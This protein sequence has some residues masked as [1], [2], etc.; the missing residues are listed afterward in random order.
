MALAPGTKLGPYE[1]QSPVG[2]GGMGQVYRARDTRLDRTVAVKILSS[3]L[4]DNPE[5]KKRFNREARAISSLNHPNICTL[6]D[7]GQKDGV[8][9]LVM[10]FLEGETL[11][12]RLMKGAMPRE[13]VLKYGV[14][15]CEGLEK[16]HRSGLVHRDLKPG[17]IMLTKSGVKL[18]DFGLAK[19]TMSPSLDA[20]ALTAEASGQPLTEKDTLVGTFQYMSPEQLQGHEA[21][22][23]SDIFALGAVLYEMIT[24]KR[25]FP[26]KSQISVAS[27]ILEKDPEP[28]T[29]SQPL[30]PPTLDHLVRTCLA[31][32][33]GERIQTAHDVKLQLKWIAASDG[34]VG[35][36]A[37]RANRERWIWISAV[38]LLFA[39]L[40]AAY[41]HK[42]S[43]PPQ[44]T[45]SSILAPENTSFAYFA[46][47]V[48]VSHDGRALTFVATSSE[49]KDMVWV[50]PLVELK[51]QALAGTEGAS[52]PFW[53]P[54][55]R[56]IGFFAG[57]RL[58]T[59]EAGGPVVTICDVAGSRGGTWSQSGII[60]FAATWGGL[61]RVPSSGGTQEEITT[62]DR[63][64][65]ELSH[66][67]PYFLPD[68]RHFLY[69]AINPSRGSAESASVYLGDLDSKEGKLLFHARSNAVYTPGYILFVRDRTLLA[70]PFDERRLEI[71]GQPFP[72][73]EQCNTMN[74]SSGECSQ[75]HSM[76]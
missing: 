32:D 70:Q 38:V 20:S 40:A 11:A 75:V 37:I 59:T 3:H 7:V 73:A 46:G 9:F 42:P 21:D 58:K 68:G 62:L 18:M 4:S 50:R 39:M 8:E 41:F 22:A 60:L 36:P 2:A 12:D 5:A 64:R 69:S 26:G 74:S 17:N 28:I 51:A 33:R 30:A 23:R 6:Y 65:G 45:W 55:G 56:S 35:M 66:R 71:L 19:E 24:G 43:S 16:A 67:W 15:I 63:S 48:A 25:A 10:E 61:H 47:P 44:P 29:A 13:Y 14:E 57:G 72:I 31:K 49:G 76:G 54:D 52:N 27:A 34:L 53:S 1:I